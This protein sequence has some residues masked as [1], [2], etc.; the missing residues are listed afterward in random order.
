LARLARLPGAKLNVARVP[1]RC[2]YYDYCFEVG[3]GE[4]SGLPLGDIEICKP[5]IWLMT[6]GVGLGEDDVRVMGR[7]L[8]CLNEQWTVG[9]HEMMLHRNYAA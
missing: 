9:F 3:S 6:R 7:R 5:L 4:L 8:R 2:R 1:P